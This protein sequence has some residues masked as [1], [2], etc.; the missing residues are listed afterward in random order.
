MEQPIRYWT[1]VIAPSG[2]TI[3]T[4]D[5]FPPWKGNACSSAACARQMLVRLELDGENGH[6]A[7]SAC[8]DN[9][10]ERI[11]DVRTG[12]DGALYLLTDNSPRDAFCG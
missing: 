10:N 4:G 11:R 7:K 5:L 2:L 8:C 9:L 6:G 1:P 3:Y 12:P